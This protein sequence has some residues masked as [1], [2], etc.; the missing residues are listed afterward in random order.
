MMRSILIVVVAIALLFAFSPVS[1]LPQEPASVSQSQE[2]ACGG[3]LRGIGRGV[4]R[5]L[6]GIGR[7]FGRSGRAC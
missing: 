6:R 5:G 3:L 1:E 7:G 2:V 4:G